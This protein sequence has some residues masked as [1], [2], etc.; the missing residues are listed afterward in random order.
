VTL[1]IFGSQFSERVPNEAR[2]GA[3]SKGG[4]FQIWSQSESDND[5][6]EL[7]CDYK[8]GCMHNIRSVLINCNSAW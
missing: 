8:T 5:C 7:T 6:E 3:S 1:V 2:F 4:Q